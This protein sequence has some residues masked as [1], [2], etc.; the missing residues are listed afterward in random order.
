[1][2]EDYQFEQGDSGSAGIEKVQAGCLK[3]GSL[4]MIK[5]HPCKVVSFSTAK[6]GKHGAAKAMV[7]GIDIFSSNKYECTFSTSENV[8]A[9][10][11]QKKEYTLVNIDDEGFMALMNES[12]EM[13]ED[14]KMP[15][16]EWLKDVTDKAREIVEAGQKEC[17]VTIVSAMGNEKLI[18]CRE[19]NNL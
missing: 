10:V 4:V 11:V 9:P 18:S 8:D 13:K 6:T 1:M 17:L 7:T 14:L 5:G 15:E 16:E 2:E 19:G 3:N 12:G